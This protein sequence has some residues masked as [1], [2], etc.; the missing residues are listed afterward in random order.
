LG[1]LLSTR[2]TN[3]NKEGP[4][5]NHMAKLDEEAEEEE[6]DRRM[7]RQIELSVDK[8]RARSYFFYFF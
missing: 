1:R 2:D 6:D 8:K 5:T 7:G 3:K 4:K